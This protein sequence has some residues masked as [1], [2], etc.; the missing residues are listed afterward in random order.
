MIVMCLFD[1]VLWLVLFQVIPLPSGWAELPGCPHQDSKDKGA[2][3]QG[4]IPEALAQVAQRSC[5]CPIPG[6]VQSQA[7][8]GFEQPGLVEGVS[9]HGRGLE[10][11][12]L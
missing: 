10:L 2:L 5:G 7:G 8:W 6:S 4:Q 9:A 1:T 11:D 12:D 3:L